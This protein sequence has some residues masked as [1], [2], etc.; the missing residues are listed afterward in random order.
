MHS[1]RV[2]SQ[3]CSGLC[4]VCT[5]LHIQADAEDEDSAVVEEEVWT[6][7][8]KVVALMA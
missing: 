8:G 2:D 6:A 1:V 5:S 4:Q 3:S 7:S